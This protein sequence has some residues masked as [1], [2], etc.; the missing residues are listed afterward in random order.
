MEYHHEGGFEAKRVVLKE[1]DFF[2][3][4]N[5]MDVAK[6]KRPEVVARDDDIKLDID[7]CQ[8]INQQVHTQCVLFLVIQSLKLRVVFL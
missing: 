7:V 4:T 2:R 3:G 5:A 8:P 6:L 1:V